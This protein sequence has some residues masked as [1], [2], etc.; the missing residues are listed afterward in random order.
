MLFFP[1]LLPLLALVSATPFTKRYS[2]AK[3]QSYRDGKCLSPNSNDY[4]N[5]V[6]VVTV[7]CDQAKTW[8]INPGSGSVILHGTN[9]ALD[10]GTGADNNEIV[11]IWTSYPGLFQQTW[12]LTGDKRIA[13]TGG[14]QCLDEGDSGPQ[15]YQCTPYNTN[16]VWNVLEGSGTSSS[17][18]AAP[19]RTCVTWSS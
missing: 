8:D 6:Q 7:N 15:T 11:K 13:I 17:S 9:F 19:S 16:Q 3:I 14:N 4:S 10:A 18:S 5:G 1:I 12:F 2:G